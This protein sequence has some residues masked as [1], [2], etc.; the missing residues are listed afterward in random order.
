MSYCFDSREK[1][2]ADYLP[3]IVGTNPYKSMVVV[4]WRDDENLE[5]DWDVTLEVKSCLNY[6][7]YYGYNVTDLAPTIF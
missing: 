5:I 1:Y 6:H 3:S 7:V 4:S 2:R